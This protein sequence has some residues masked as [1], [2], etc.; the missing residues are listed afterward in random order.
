MKWEG[1]ITGKEQAE[2]G[3]NWKKRYKTGRH[4][5]NVEKCEETGRKRK[6]REET[7]GIQEE[8]GRKR[9]DGKKN[10]GKWYKRERNWG[11]QGLFQPIPVYSCPFQSIP[12]YS[13]IF[14][15]MSAFYSLLQ[16]H[17]IFYIWS[18]SRCLKECFIFNENKE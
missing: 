11:K 14:Q 1:K 5:N 9:R 10:G 7:A 3:R 6:K 4:R 16:T 18:F 17:K 8:T 12:A 2:T 15:P 13:S